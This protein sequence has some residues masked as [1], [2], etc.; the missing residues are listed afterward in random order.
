VQDYLAV[1]RLRV[2]QALADMGEHVELDEDPQQNLF[3]RAPTRVVAVVSPERS[4]E[5]LNADEGRV[6]HTLA[7]AGEH[8]DGVAV[9]LARELL[10]HSVRGFAATLEEA[11]PDWPTIRAAIDL[12]QAGRKRKK[13]LR[14]LVAERDKF[15]ACLEDMNE[16][17]RERVLAHAL[18]R[19][20]NPDEAREDIEREQ[21][22]RSD[23][24]GKNEDTPPE[25]STAEPR[26]PSGRKR[27]GKKA[28][29]KTGATVKP[30]KPAAT[31][32]KRSAKKAPKRKGKKK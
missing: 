25:A 2:A 5:D 8:L 12:E 27:K 32:K 10:D 23:D 19:S 31:K 30:T 18:D 16:A 11:L 3:D 6:A 28:P 1:G 20:L 7:D 13:V 22:P 21:S 29:P 15:E 24:D 9:Q 4:P 26:K 14:A 17:D